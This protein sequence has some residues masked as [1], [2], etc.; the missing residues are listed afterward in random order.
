MSTYDF[1]RQVLHNV[2]SMS[3][4]STKYEH[5]LECNHMSS[6]MQMAHAGVR[7]RCHACT[8]SC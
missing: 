5:P 6:A 1:L 3:S 2:A 8:S 4:M 7:S